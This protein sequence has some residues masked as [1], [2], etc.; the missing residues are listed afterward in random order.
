MSNF[1]K[2]KK[3][4]FFYKT[5]NVLSDAVSSILTASNVDN[6]VLLANL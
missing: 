5:D 3:I 4:R 1:T 6:S 2:M